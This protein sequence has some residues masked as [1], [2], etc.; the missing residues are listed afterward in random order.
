MHESIY[1]HVSKYECKETYMIMYLCGN[2][3]MYVHTCKYVGR[4]V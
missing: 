1:T 3:W 4:H 2:E